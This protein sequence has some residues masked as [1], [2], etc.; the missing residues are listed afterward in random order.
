VS[1][2]LKERTLELLTTLNKATLLP[3]SLPLLYFTS[4][5]KPVEIQRGISFLSPSPTP[6]FLSFIPFVP[7]L[8]T[9]VKADG[10]YSYH[11][12]LKG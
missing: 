4:G 2:R 5:K 1:Q 7:L 6:F 9:G 12:A 11:W 8:V 10:S 3:R